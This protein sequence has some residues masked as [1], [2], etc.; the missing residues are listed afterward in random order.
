MHLGDLKN[1]S[2]RVRVSWFLGGRGNQE[3]NLNKAINNNK[4]NPKLKNSDNPSCI[5]FEV[6]FLFDAC[7]YCG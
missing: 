6:L 2:G 3:K 1:L 5:S 7:V 4:L